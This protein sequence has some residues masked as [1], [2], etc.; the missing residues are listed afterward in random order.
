[1]GPD[2]VL[3]PKFSAT[4]WANYQVLWQKK[5]FVQTSSMGRIFDAVAALLGVLDV[6]TYEGEAA[7]RLEEL[8]WTYWNAD[9]PMPGGY[10][11][12]DQISPQHLLLQIKT[13][14]QGGLPKNLIAFKFHFSLI[15][16]ITQ[17]AIAEGVQRIAFSGGVWQN[18]LLVDLALSQLHG[19]RLYFHQE[20]SPNDEGVALGQVAV[21]AMMKSLKIL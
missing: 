1:L 3:E 14:L 13:D 19:F 2:P 12:D 20:T 16:L 6:Q 10:I 17:I 5:H 4:E 18:S 8:A 21:W 11:F 15:Q 9:K 7:L